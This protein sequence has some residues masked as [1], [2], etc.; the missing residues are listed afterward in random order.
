MH[1]PRCIRFRVF[2]LRRKKRNFRPLYTHLCRFTR[3]CDSYRFTDFCCF[4]S[5]CKKN[6]KSR[7]AKLI[8]CLMKHHAMGSGG[9]VPRFPNSGTERMGMVNFRP[10]RLIPLHQLNGMMGGPHSRHERFE[11]HAIKA[12]AN[13]FTHS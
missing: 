10:R 3:A 1:C 12:Y 5:T 9:T 7:Y 2:Q 4:P 11:H 8:P 13:S 6:A